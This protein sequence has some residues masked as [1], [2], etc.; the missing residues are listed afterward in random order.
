MGECQHHP[1]SCMC[2]GDNP[3]MNQMAMFYTLPEWCLARKKQGGNGIKTPQRGYIRQVEWGT[4]IDQLARH[5]MD[6]EEDSKTDPAGASGPQ[7]PVC[8]AHRCPAKKQKAKSTL[9][10]SFSLW[11]HSSIHVLDA[12]IEPHGLS[13][14]RIVSICSFRL[15]EVWDQGAGRVE[16]WGRPHFLIHWTSST[17]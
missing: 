11:A 10:L 12:L 9:F 5:P 6:G 8:T 2:Q 7:H 15:W 16:G 1:T 4:M 17:R 3:A 13:D 14:L